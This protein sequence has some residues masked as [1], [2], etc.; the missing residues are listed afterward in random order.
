MPTCAVNELRPIRRC[1]ICA[2]GRMLIGTTPELM[3]TGVSGLAGRRDAQYPTSQILHAVM[4]RSA[5][6]NSGQE[7]GRGGQLVDDSIL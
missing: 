6:P 7:I 3:A 1:A 2:C 4:V 5:I